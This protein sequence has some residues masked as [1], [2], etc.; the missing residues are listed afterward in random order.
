MTAAGRGV[1]QRNC[2]G[3]SHCTQPSYC[4]QPPG[5]AT[6]CVFRDNYSTVS[7]EGFQWDQTTE[8][9][10]SNILFIFRN[11]CQGDQNDS[12]YIISKT[13][14]LLDLHF[15]LQ[16]NVTNTQLHF[17]PC[18]PLWNMRT[19]AEFH[20]TSVRFAVFFTPTL[21]KVER[22]ESEIRSEVFGLWRGTHPTHQN[23]FV[24]SWSLAFRETFPVTWSGTLAKS[25][26]GGFTVRAKRFSALSEK[27]LFFSALWLLLSF[28]QTR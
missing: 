22:I 28:K 17:C 9:W 12:K 21:S 10:N 19:V 1:K 16:H 27:C 18:R 20:E 3:F 11:K 26:N 25:T 6:S 8:P 23:T 14:S 5:A 13:L 4:L 7:R 24:L 15:T 2:A